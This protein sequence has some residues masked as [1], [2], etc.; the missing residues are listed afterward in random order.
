MTA[1]PS[2]PYTLATLADDG[3]PPKSRLTDARQGM[4]LFTRLKRSA[5]ARLSRAAVIQGMR[6]GNAPFDPSRLLNRN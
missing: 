4:E 3:K 6:D 1:T 2:N 5:D